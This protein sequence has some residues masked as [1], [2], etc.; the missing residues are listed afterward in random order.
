MELVARG[1]GTARPRVTIP[2]VTRDRAAAFE[3]YERALTTN[4]AAAL[5]ALFWDSPHTLRHGTAENLYGHAEIAAFRAARSPAG[6]AR[7]LERTVITTYGRDFATADTLFR[8]EGNPAIG[9]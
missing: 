6:L 1:L 5:N 8:R 9:R 2:E 7:G 3:L 4:D